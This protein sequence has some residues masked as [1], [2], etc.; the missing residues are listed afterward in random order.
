MLQNSQ[1][2]QGKS[3][4]SLLLSQIRHGGEDIVELS[5]LG[6]IL[7]LYCIATASN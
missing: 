1:R 4:V 2:K 7:L 5:S 3:D 6:A